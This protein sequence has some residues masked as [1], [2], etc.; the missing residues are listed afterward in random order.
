MTHTITATQSDYID[1]NYTAA[2]ICAY[3]SCCWLY[4]WDRDR[5]TMR[6]PGGD[7]G[8]EP[9]PMLVSCWCADDACQGCSEASC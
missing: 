2:G 1:A 8:C 4:Q 6:T 5:G 7:T 3:W 9:S